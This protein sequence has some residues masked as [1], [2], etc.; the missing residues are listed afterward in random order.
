[1]TSQ[2]TVLPQLNY[3][4]HGF[5]ARAL[6]DS[7]VFPIDVYAQIVRHNHKHRVVSIDVKVNGFNDE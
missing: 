5:D 1:M 7:V 2:H 3:V 6:L 4:S